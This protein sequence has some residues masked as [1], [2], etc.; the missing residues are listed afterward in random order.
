MKLKYICLVIMSATISYNN[1]SLRAEQLSSTSFTAGNLVVYRVGEGLVSLTNSATA[2]FLDEYTPTG[3]LVQSVAVPT[4]DGNQLTDSGVATSDGEITRSTDGQY[5]V[6]T[7]YRTALG[8]AGIASSSAATYPRVVGL[9]NAS[10]NMSSRS[11]GSTTFNSN[12]IRSTASVDGTSIYATGGNGV[13]NFS[14]SGSGETQ[15]G[16]YNTRQANIFASRLYVSSGS[17]TNTF[18]GVDTFSSALPT[19]SETLTRLPGLSDT[20]DPSTYGFFMADL[21]PAVTGVDTLYIA[22]DSTGV[23]TKFCLDS[24][25]WVSKGSIG[26]DADDY[27]GLTGVVSGDSVTL[28]ATI[29]GGSAGS[30]GGQLVS[31][32]DASGYDGAFSDTPTTLA[33]AANY[34]AFRGVALA[35]IEVPEPSVVVLLLI[36][37]LGLVVR[38]KR[39]T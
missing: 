17:G 4:T 33:T 24:G 39:K 23:F 38:F 29:K 21:S 32:M 18:K 6:F 34:E 15:L 31:L 22:D 16:T 26:V 7:G 25:S 28:Y 1:P 5:L 19:S 30:G 12:N 2:V 3:T 27:R 10:A 37:A 11:L 20:T 9:V 35:P 13:Y 8:T 36:A 14:F